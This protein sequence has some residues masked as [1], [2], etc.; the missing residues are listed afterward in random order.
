MEHSD[1]AISEAMALF[2]EESELQDLE[3]MRKLDQQSEYGRVVS[4]TL[5]WRSGGEV[6]EKSLAVV[7]EN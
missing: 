7:I 3:N 4:E 1:D 2:D 5:W 6:V